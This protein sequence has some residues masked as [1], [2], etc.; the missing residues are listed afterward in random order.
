M[1]RKVV[2]S[3]QFSNFIAVVIVLNAIT[4]GLETS[5]SIMEKWGPSL[6]L[7][8]AIALGI[9]C[10][11]IGAKLFF[12]RL[13]FF[14]SGWN[15]F[16]L[17]IVLVALNSGTFA[18]LR[19]LRILRVLRLFSV[20]GTLRRVVSALLN[21]IPSLGSIAA[22]MVIWFYICAVMATNLFGQGFPEWFGTIGRSLYS[23][24]QITTL[25]SW[26]MGIVRPVMEVYPQA[27][28][29]FVPFIIVSTFTVLNLFIAVLVSSIQTVHESEISVSKNEDLLT[30]I[31]SL[32]R[33]LAQLKK[34]IS[35]D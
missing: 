7:F 18:V 27:W 4:L 35:S 13:R 12:E 22:I 1:M 33:S 23:L 5:V 19:S 28:A 6:K 31:E 10:F 24:F 30:S 8:D 17:A 26:S 29:F 9:F 16:D 20:L 11:E 21:A 25:E 34:K 32:E 2:Y 3:K 14:K 15:V